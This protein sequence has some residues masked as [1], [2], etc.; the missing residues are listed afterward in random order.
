MRYGGRGEKM[1]GRTR[2]GK[3]HDDRDFR[4]V[5]VI[6]NLC[7]GVRRSVPARIRKSGIRVET[8]IGEDG[9]HGAG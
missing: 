3:R 9:R 6:R 2:P 7:L 5:G 8:D 1:K 4:L